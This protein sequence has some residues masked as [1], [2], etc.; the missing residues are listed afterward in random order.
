[1]SA[2]E[3]EKRELIERYKLTD[4]ILQQ[5]CSE[6]DLLELEQFIDWERVGPRLH[7]IDEIAMKDIEKNCTKEHE[8]R[9]ELI[10]IWRE[11]NGEDA[12]YCDMIEA[13]LKAQRRDQAQ[14]VCRLLNPGK[15]LLQN[16]LGRIL[17]RQLDTLSLS[18]FCATVAAIS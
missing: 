15:S 8:K 18:C 14:K 7:R 4:D 9:R 17:G 3:K 11:R 6:A 13:M 10:N 1:M 12:N 5:S 2:L 16:I